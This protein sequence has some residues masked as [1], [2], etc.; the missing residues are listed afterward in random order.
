MS[1]SQT[2]GESKLKESLQPDHSEHRHPEE[3]DIDD[4]MTYY[5]SMEYA[6]RHLLINK[7]YITAAQIR[8]EIEKM[9]AR[10]PVNGANIVAR[11][12]IDSDFKKLL[13]RNPRQAI[14]KFGHDIGPMNLIIL[15]NTPK[16]HNVVVCTLCSCY[17][18]WIL[19]LPPD[20]YKSSAYRARVIREP[21]SV[22][23]EF[24]TQIDPKRE[25]RVHDS[26]ADM[27]YMVLPMRPTG[28]DGMSSSELSSLVGRD[29]MIGVAEVK[30]D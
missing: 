4:S 17:P 22:L 15:E 21:R 26:T 28:T 20:W 2:S 25:V 18:R 16:V 3:P 14:E 1:N 11:A 30:V 19:G 13:L 29:S 9:D 24:G 27:R 5:K 6:V 8:D 23:R 10:T 12:W 7:G